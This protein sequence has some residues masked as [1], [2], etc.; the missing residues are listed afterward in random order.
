MY[1]SAFYLIHFH[2]QGKKLY[3][4]VREIDAIPDNSS[5]VKIDFS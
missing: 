5:L 2:T 4:W 1:M 3:Q